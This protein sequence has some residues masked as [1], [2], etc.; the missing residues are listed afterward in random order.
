MADKLKD[1]YKNNPEIISYIALRDG[2]L[3]IDI[4]EDKTTT[5]DIMLVYSNVLTEYI[6]SSA[7]L[8]EEVSKNITP[9][10]EEDS[11]GKN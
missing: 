9:T 5:T 6:K 3:I 10:N 11:D 7:S 2:K 1:V 8:L 4:N